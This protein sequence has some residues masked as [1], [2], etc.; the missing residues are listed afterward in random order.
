MISAPKT[1]CRQGME[2]ANRL[3]IRKYLVGLAL[4]RDTG[5]LYPPHAL[6]V[7]G[8]GVV[9]RRIDRCIVD[10]DEVVD[11]VRLAQ[12]ERH[13]CLGSPVEIVRLALVHPSP[14]LGLGS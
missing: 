4:A 11:D 5:L 9:Q 10:R 3:E 6:D 2:P 12:G 8:K 14:R 7:L 1:A 13:G